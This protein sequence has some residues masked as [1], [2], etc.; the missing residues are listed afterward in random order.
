MG[1]A[2]ALANERGLPFKINNIRGKVEF[3]LDKRG[4][5]KVNDKLVRGIPILLLSESSSVIIQELGSVWPHAYMLL[6]LNDEFG[7][8]QVGQEVTTIKHNEFVVG[9]GLV[10]FGFKYLS[11]ISDLDIFDHVYIDGQRGEWE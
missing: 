7:V 9:D 1:L 8:M 11:E 4:V 5:A 6:H 10:A 2:I 3:G